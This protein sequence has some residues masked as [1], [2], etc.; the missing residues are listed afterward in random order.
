MIGSRITNRRAQARAVRN[1]RNLPPYERAVAAERIIE[2]A[3]QFQ[4]QLG[5]LRRE[6][7]AELRRAGLTWREVGLLI[8]V[9]PDRARRM[10]LNAPNSKP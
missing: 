5:A 6:A 2:E 9:V 3:R 10:G 7:A 1:L 4:A 8:G